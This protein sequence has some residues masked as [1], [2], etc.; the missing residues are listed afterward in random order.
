M[1]TAKDLFD[2]TIESEENGATLVSDGLELFY[3]KSEALSEMIDCE[4]NEDDIMN[5]Y[6]AWCVKNCLKG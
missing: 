6:D 3:V 4:E 5:A 2:L 1:K